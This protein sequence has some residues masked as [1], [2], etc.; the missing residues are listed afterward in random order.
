VIRAS[1]L[2]TAEQKHVWRI[3]NEFDTK[4][5]CWAAQSYLAQL[6]GMPAADFVRALNEVIRLGLIHEASNGKAIVF[7]ATIP[8]MFPATATLT[9]A[10]KLG[11]ALELDAIITKQ[12]E[13]LG[14]A[15][16]KSVPNE[17]PKPF[18]ED[19]KNESPKGGIPRGG[20]ERPGR[21]TTDPGVLAI[22]E[23]LERKKAAIQR[24]AA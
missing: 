6:V 4:A 21:V 7:F 11:W 17:V 18:G 1:R 13:S 19:S 24:G 22:L 16:P 8:A 3:V 14:T 2:L 9:T 20:K 5:G 12:V 10:E 15:V 23:K